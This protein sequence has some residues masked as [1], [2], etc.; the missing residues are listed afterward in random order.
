[1]REGVWLYIGTLQGHVTVVVVG[2]T[3]QYGTHINTATI[4]AGL[5][6]SGATLDCSVAHAKTTP[7]PMPW[8]RRKVAAMLFTVH[9]L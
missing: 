7:F 9:F 4:H 5:D 8:Q 3:K 1:M 2:R 6:G